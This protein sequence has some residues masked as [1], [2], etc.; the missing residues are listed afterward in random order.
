MWYDDQPGDGIT[1][2]FNYE[3]RVIGDRKTMEETPPTKDYL[4]ICE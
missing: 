4:F 2:F 3:N 1:S